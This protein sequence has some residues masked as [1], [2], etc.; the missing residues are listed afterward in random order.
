LAYAEELLQLARNLAQQNNQSQAALRRA[1]STAYY[2]LFHLLVSEASA[3]WS[4]EKLRPELGRL[5]QHARMKGA[6][7]Q[8]EDKAGKLMKD[9]QEHEQYVLTRALRLVAGTFV[10]TQQHREDADYN[11]RKTWTEPEVLDKIKDVED[12]LEAWTQ[13]RNE[14][15]AQEYLLS[16][17][18]TRQRQDA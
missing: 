16:L 6:S 3:N 15:M 17:L 7:K 14:D 12:A 13:I 1:M 2:A 8:L 9:N 18:G 11:I 5:F 10:A 4:R